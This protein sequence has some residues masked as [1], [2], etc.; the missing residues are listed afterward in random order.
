MWSISWLKVTGLEY[1]DSTGTSMLYAVPVLI[2]NYQQSTGAFVN[3]GTFSLCVNFIIFNQSA[4][5][6]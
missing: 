5:F 6:C 3:T 2:L 4:L 1:T